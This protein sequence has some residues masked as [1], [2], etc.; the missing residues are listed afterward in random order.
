MFCENQADSV[1]AD[2]PPGCVDCSAD[3][4]PGCETAL[5]SVCAQL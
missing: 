4:P 1:D 2:F 5:V 3:F